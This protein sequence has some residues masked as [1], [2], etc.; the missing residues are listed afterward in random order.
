MIATWVGCFTIV[1]STNISTKCTISGQ[2]RLP[3]LVFTATQLSISSVTFY[4]RLCRWYWSVHTRPLLGSWSHWLCLTCWTRTVAIIS[5]NFCHWSSRTIS[6]ISSSPSATESS[7]SW[8]T[9]TAPTDSFE[10]PGEKPHP[11]NQ[12]HLTANFQIN[13]NKIK[14]NSMDSID[15]CFFTFLTWYVIKTGQPISVFP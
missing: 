9:S 11:S 3:W 1:P 15:K 7:V 13:Q 5:S 14:V 8:T 12:S 4:P 2:P 10:R 6:I